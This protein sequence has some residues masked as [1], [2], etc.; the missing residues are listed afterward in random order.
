MIKYNMHVISDYK[1]QN[2]H[3]NKC[4]DVPTKNSGKKRKM[5]GKFK[6]QNA[7]TFMVTNTG[8][9]HFIFIPHTLQSLYL[10]KN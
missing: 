4:V 10:Q 6:V 1:K 9:T 3:L 7:E 8:K 2:F 5:E